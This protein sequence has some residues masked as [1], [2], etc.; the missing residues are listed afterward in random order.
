MIGTKNALPSF[1]SS[2]NEQ[3]S[4]KCQFGNLHLESLPAL[5]HGRRPVVKAYWI[6]FGTFDVSQTSIACRCQYSILSNNPK[7][8]QSVAAKI[9]GLSHSGLLFDCGPVVSLL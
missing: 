4:N 1:Q 7:I 6:P 3:R 8:A 2:Q 5:R 9:T